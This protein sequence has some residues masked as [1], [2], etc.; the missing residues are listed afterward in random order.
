MSEL[1]TRAITGLGIVAVVVGVTVMGQLPTQI[2]VIA[3]CAISSYELISMSIPESGNLTK[4]T[5]VAF[6][7]LP[8]VWIM[9]QALQ[10]D[11]PLSGLPELFNMWVLPL[12]LGLY[13]VAIIVAGVQK[14]F[15]HITSM[16]L[17][18]LLFS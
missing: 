18:I 7:S 16:G 1:S 10:P 14:P 6:T 5:F 9:A 15:Q 4:I 12:A 8:L 2:F 13:V 3:I 11:T 17:A